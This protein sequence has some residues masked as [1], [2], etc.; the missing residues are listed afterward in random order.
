MRSS[1]WSR[2]AAAL[3]V[4]LAFGAA[5]APAV[6]FLVYNNQ[7][8]VDVNPGD[9]MCD[10]DPSPPGI[11]CTLRAAVMEAN[12]L[13][14][15]DVIRVNAATYDLTIPADGDDGDDSGDLEIED[16]LTIENVGVRPTIDGQ[17][18]HRIFEL[19]DATSLTLRG[20][21][22]RHGAAD[23]GGCVHALDDLVLER[24]TMVS[25]ASTQSGGGLFLN[26]GS[27]R[28]SDS[29]F[30]AN[31]TGGIGGGLVFFGSLVNPE[32]ALI[33][34]STFSGNLAFRGGGLTAN[35]EM[36]IV[37]ST[38][39]GNSAEDVG[40]GVFTTDIGRMSNVTIVGNFADSDSDNVGSG[41]GLFKS[42]SDVWTV[43]NSTIVLN[44]RTP[45]APV[46]QDCNGTFASG[47][48]NLIGIGSGCTGFAGAGDTVGAGPNP[49]D[50]VIGGLIHR[51]GWTP[52][53]APLAGSP[54]LQ[55]GDPA[56]CLTDLDGTGPGAPAVLSEDQR[57]VA[58]PANGRC[59]RGSV[60]IGPIFFDGFV[61]GTTERWSSAVI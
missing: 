14:G 38:F 39:Y 10:A 1:H 52:T 18:L 3:A 24:V 8:Q 19:L 58:R 54:L 41:G 48:Y 13:A 28:V 25:C 59:E 5:P 20:L 60:E 30:W 55:A 53:M 61:T 31:Q 51:G 2:G 46:W 36:V 33:E 29:W 9:G 27:L 32:R 37:N 43:E 34:R 17:D 16:D 12:A 50:P 11:T 45:S 7:D 4:A 6:N 15:P 23:Y 26:G 49:I 42:V 44:R 56:G 40:G 21:V 47:G 35:G 57:G 22:L